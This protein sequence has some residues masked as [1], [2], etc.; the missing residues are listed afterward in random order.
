MTRNRMLVTGIVGFFV[1][2]LGCVTPV[3]VALLA[4]F[5]ISGSMGWLDY[6][7]LP[8]MAIFA[9]LTAYAIVCRRRRTVIRS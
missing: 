7:L 2:M 6:I 3:M 1:S 8:G 5:G 4:A 9:A